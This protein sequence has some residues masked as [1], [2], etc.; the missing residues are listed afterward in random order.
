MKAKLCIATLSA[1]LVALPM[2]AH[3]ATSTPAPT[4]S[5]SSKPKVL[6]QK[7][8]AAVQSKLRTVLY[9]LTANSGTLNPLA[10]I[11]DGYSLT[12]MGADP[13]TTWFTDRPYRDSGVLPSQV[14][15]K[16]FSVTKDPANVALVF[17][18]PT[19]GTDTL[20]AV[21]RK[22]AFDTSTQTF[23][24][25]I[26]LLSAQEQSKVTNGLKRHVTRAD[27]TA[28][29]SFKEASLFIDTNYS[30]T[31]A[32][33]ASNPPNPQVNDTYQWIGGGPYGQ[34]NCWTLYQ[35]MGSTYGGWQP[36]GNGCPPPANSPGGG[37]FGIPGFSFFP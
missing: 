35:F 22:S 24:A 20:V 2:A 36:I 18:Q 28:P 6:S 29:T 30:G 5:A 23:T 27:T 11:K 15:A 16:S 8:V 21:M 19:Q 3:A 9:S 7:Q 12:L 10:G 26:R 31:T 34:G 17:H 32:P 13:S 37:V 4:A 1:I 33:S 14:V 25:E